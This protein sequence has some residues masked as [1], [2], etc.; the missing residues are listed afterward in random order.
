MSTED[1]SDVLEAIG[2][3]VAEEVATLL[4]RPPLAHLLDLN[5]FEQSREI[6]IEGEIDGDFGAWFRK[7]MRHLES[8]SHEPITVWID[9]PGGDEVSMF[10]FYDIVTSSPCQVTTVGGGEICSAGVLMLACG[11]PGQRLV[12]ENCV[13]MSHEGGRGHA[14]DGL[15]YSESKDRRKYEDWTQKQWFVL[16]ARHTERCN[17]ER[18]EAFWKSITNRRAEYWRLGAE[19]IIEDGIA[20]AIYSPTRLPEPARR[21]QR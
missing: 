4:P 16:M 20:D 5:V 17:P 7:V 6:F 21:R 13:L 12:T 15:R 14:G 3:A 11:S 18:N 2:E 8:I 19:E 1:Q 9:T 10:S